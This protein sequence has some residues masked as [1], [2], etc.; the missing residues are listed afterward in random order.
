MKHLFSF[1]LVIFCL[2]LYAQRSYKKTYFENGTL[3]SEGWI[4]NTNKIDYWYFY[5][6]N[7]KIREE[8]HFKN[9]KKQNIEKQRKWQVILFVEMKILRFYNADEKMA[10]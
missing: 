2:Q 7:G 10:D 4:E 5:Y 6:Q 9:N 8:G 1:I 3:A